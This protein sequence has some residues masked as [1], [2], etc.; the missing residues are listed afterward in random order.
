MAD[1]ASLSAQYRRAYALSLPTYVAADD[2]LV[3]TA[4]RMSGVVQAACEAGE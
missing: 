3:F 4:L 1:F 2:Y